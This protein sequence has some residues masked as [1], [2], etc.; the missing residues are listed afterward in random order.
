E[1]ESHVASFTTLLGPWDAL[2]VFGG[3]QNE[4]S[5]QRGFGTYVE[6]GVAM[7]PRSDLDK[8]S[9][10]EHA[11]L[12]YTKIPF[13]VLFADARFRQENIGQYEEDFPDTSPYFLQRDTDATANSKD[14]RAGFTT[15]PWSRISFG[16]CYRWADNKTRY[17]HILDQDAA[18]GLG[19]SAFIR[20]R[21]I[22]TDEIELKLVLRP[23]SWITTTFQYKLASVD[24][25][26]DTDPLQ[27]PG[28]DI[29][30]GGAL[31]AGSYDTHTYSANL[32]ITPL[33][34]LYFAGTFSHMTAASR[35]EANGVPSVV[36]Y[37]GDTY[38]FLGSA[39]YA[40]SEKTDLQAG[41]LF[42]YAD[43]GQDNFADGLP[44]GMVYHQ[45]G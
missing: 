13:T 44:L 8:V 15:S 43:F 3:V 17:N 19:Y 1:R 40:L 30:P 32:V 39:T 33:A 25:V 23:A 31:P 14:V 4:W 5:R 7:Q 29:T 28:L 36:P 37:K 16:A 41:Y 21:D 20:A 6:N 10:E 45:H 24:Q 27:V 34:R 2:S 42:S 12:R 26:T 35:T 18:G 38:N 11:G 22:R 9:I